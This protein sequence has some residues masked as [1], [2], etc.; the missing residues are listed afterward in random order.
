MSLVVISSHSLIHLFRPFQMGCFG[1]GMSR[2]VA[3]SVEYL[4]SLYQDQASPDNSELQGD[5]GRTIHFGSNMIILRWP[6]LIV[7][8]KVCIIMPKKDSKE[9]KG[10]GTDFSNH[11]VSIIQNNYSED[12]LIDDRS[13][14]T[15]GK[16]LLTTRA[17]GIPFIIVAGR[18]I[19]D[20]IP[21]FEV[22]N[23]YSDSPQTPQLMTQVEVLDFLSH[24]L[25]QFNFPVNNSGHFL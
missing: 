6:K 24:N 12:V 22:F 11:L 20:S 18:N 19:I 10:K 7:P 17:V 21:K 4:S 23:T 25:K 1:L 16:R 3:S 5:D 2:I 15:I 8:F 9:D 13:N 14:L